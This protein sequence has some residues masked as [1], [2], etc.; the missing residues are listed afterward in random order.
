MYLRIASL[1]RVAMGIRD[2]LLVKVASRR[3]FLPAP[4]GHSMPLRY[5]S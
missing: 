3:F 1:L 4:G 5:A 2:A